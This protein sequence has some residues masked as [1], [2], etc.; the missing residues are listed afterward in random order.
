VSA[1]SGATLTSVTTSGTG[2]TLA[3]AEG[4]GAASTA[5]GSFTT[6]LATHSSGIRDAAGNLASYAATAPTD[7]AAPA[8]VTLTLLDNDTDGKVDRLTALF[9]ETLQSY[10]AGTT[11][12]TLTNVPSAGTLA[13][14]AVSTATATLT[15]TEG[16]GAADTSVGSMTV[17][18]A[19][20]AAGVRDAA[21]NRGAFAARAPLDGA[22]PV[23]LT[24]TDSNGTTNGR[25]QSGDSISITF[26]EPLAPATVPASTTL[27]L[28]GGTSA[29]DTLSM[30][31]ISN[32]AGSTGGT[33]YVTTNGG[34]AAWTSAVALSNANKTVTVTIGGS[35]SGTGC[36]A[37]GTQLTNGTYSYVAATT[38][39]DVAGNTPRTTALTSSLRLF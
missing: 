22:K 28:T 20:N 3:L 37:L 29:S 21:G 33:S 23:P 13:G 32:G 35:C 26:S 19:S 8:L 38:L 15:L 12:W 39:T 7:R 25:A 17:A 30:T 6:A 11:P 1:P 14:V 5:V 27:T 18:M 31:G 36:A 34:V 24:I 10:T 4:A 2:A 9:S 16:T